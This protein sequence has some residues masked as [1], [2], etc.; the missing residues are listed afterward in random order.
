MPNAPTRNTIANVTMRSGRRETYRNP[1]ASREAPDVPARG[2]SSCGR[3][4]RS[5]TTIPKKVTALTRKTQPVPTATMTRPA[6]AGPIIRAPLKDAAFSAT[7]FDA[8]SRVTTSETNACRA[9][10][11]KADTTPSASA[12]PYMIM[13]VMWP[14]RIITPRPIAS[15]NSRPW[16]TMSSLRRSKRSATQPVTPTSSS[17]GANCSAMVTPIAAA[18]LSVSS[19]ST[20]QFWAVACIHAPMLETNA[21]MNHTR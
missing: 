7:A 21:P 9:G 4:S 1:S 12:K 16:V 13:R 15:R 3:I 18:S 5:A 8:F 20:T 19:V 6:T 10:L 14:V 17:G 11:S 2:S